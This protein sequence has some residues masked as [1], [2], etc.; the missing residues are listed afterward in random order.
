VNLPFGYQ[1]AWKPDFD[2]CETEVEMK[3]LVDWYAIHRDGVSLHL[4][5]NSYHLH[6]ADVLDPDF[7]PPRDGWTMT[8]DVK[9]GAEAV[10][11]ESLPNY[12]FKYPF[13]VLPVVTENEATSF[14]SYLE[15]E[16]NSCTLLL[17][18]RCDAD[19]FELE[20]S[21]NVDL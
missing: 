4:I 6:K 17:G 8:W 18:A 11:H 16:A 5:D 13:P 12:S 20:T 2:C 9:H 19:T 15:S 1:Y 21:M 14:P 7:T 10:E 3:P